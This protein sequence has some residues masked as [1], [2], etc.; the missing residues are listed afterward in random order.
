MSKKQ[1]QEEVKTLRFVST[2]L[3][4]GITFLAIIC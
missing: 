3:A 1:L 4:I 2:V